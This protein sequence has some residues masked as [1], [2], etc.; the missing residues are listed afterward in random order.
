MPAF[1]VLHVREHSTFDE[2][3]LIGNQFALVIPDDVIVRAL[4]GQEDHPSLNPLGGYHLR[5]FD[6]IALGIPAET[7]HH[8]T[9]CRRDH[10]HLVETVLPRI[11][12]RGIR[13]VHLPDGLGIE[14]AL[15]APSLP[16]TIGKE[17]ECAVARPPGHAAGTADQSAAVAYLEGRA[18]D[19]LDLGI[20]D[21]PAEDRP[22]TSPIELLG[23]L[24]A[25][26]QE[27]GIRIVLMVSLDERDYPIPHLD[28][29]G[30]VSGATVETE[31]LP[32]ADL[33]DEPLLPYAATEPHDEGTVAAGLPGRRGIQT[34][35]TRIPYQVEILELPDYLR[36]EECRAIP[37]HRIGIIH[38]D[39]HLIHPWSRRTRI[40]NVR[41]ISRAARVPQ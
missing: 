11:E 34:D 8:R 31:D 30:F 24:D 12:R 25:G 13:V 14:D 28:G 26:Y 39:V 6:H 32:V 5:R 38:C 35:E 19:P 36:S 29:I 1:D 23:R 37:A 21:A 41:R 4:I 9:G 17:L 40:W 20:D 22:D 15:G 16:R 3:G 18:S 10:R 33:A 7:V 27:T 2:I